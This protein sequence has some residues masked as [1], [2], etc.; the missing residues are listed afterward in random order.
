[1]FSVEE[2][3]AALTYVLNTCEPYDNAYTVISRSIQHATHGPVCA[4]VRYTYPVPWLYDI[5]SS[6]LGGF[7]AGSASP[8]L[9]PDEYM[10]DGNCQAGQDSGS[11]SAVC[12]GIG[13]G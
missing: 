9:S 13:A 3:R 8:A 12:V 5:S 11:V 10:P 2:I 4:A 7:Y 1:M 6:V